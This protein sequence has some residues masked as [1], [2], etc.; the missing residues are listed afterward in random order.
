MM[1][2]REIR[3]AIAAGEIEIDPFN[4]AQLQPASYDLLLGDS[5]QIANEKDLVEGFYGA[6][7]FDITTDVTSWH[8]FSLP[9]AVYKNTFVLGSTFERIRL[10]PGIAMQ[11]TGKSTVGRHG[12]T[13]H[14]TAGHVDPGWDGDLTLEIAN[15]GPFAIYLTPQM[16]I[17]QAVF[18]RLGE[19]CE[20]PYAGQYQG[21]RGPRAPGLLK[22]YL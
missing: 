6:K 16:P 20:R 5:V 19:L 3:S 21:Q 4:P 13:V 10:G 12:L 7:V 2:D 14:I 9:C 8:E 18:F 22:R 15:L 17:A 1:S 11:L